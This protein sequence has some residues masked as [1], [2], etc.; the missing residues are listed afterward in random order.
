MNQA[1]SITKEQYDQLINMMQQFHITNANKE[2]EVQMNNAAVN[3]AGIMAFTSFIDFSKPSCGCFKN[4]SDLWIL[5]SEATHHMTFNKN[6]MTNLITLPYP[7]LLRLPNCYRVKVTEI[8]SV[9]ISTQI[10]LYK[11]LFVPSFKY[12]LMS[13]HSL[14]MHLKCIASFSDSSCILQFSDSSCVLLGLSMKS[15]LEIGKVF[16]SL[17]FLFSDCIQRNTPED[18][19]K[20]QVSFPVSSH[21][22]CNSK[23]QC[24][25]HPTLVPSL[26]SHVSRVHYQ[27]H[28]HSY[29]P[30]SF[31]INSIHNN[32]DN[33]VDS[34]SSVSHKF[35]DN[36]LWHNRLGE[37][38]LITTY[39]VNKLPSAPLKS[40]C[41]FEILYSQK[42]FYSHLRS[43]DCLCYPTTPK[44]HRTKFDPRATPH[45][46][47]GYPFGTKGYKVLSLITKKIQ[48]SRDVVFHENIFPFC[49]STPSPSIHAS[50]SPFEH[51]LSSTQSPTHGQSTYEQSPASPD[52]TTPIMSP[53]HSDT[54]PH[55]PIQ[56]PI[57]PPNSVTR[58][59]NSS[60]LND[61]LLAPTLNHS[62]SYSTN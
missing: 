61:T 17:Y 3:F 22:C 62:F 38:I 39:I 56:P 20:T 16:D 18:H 42:P 35:D 36:L 23:L 54:Q 7:L 37:C 57:S 6:Q 58:T 33:A 51:D 48:I 47:V 29:Q 31:V 32:K 19:N 46:F 14:V 41:P 26:S 4:R 5:D 25:S 24:Q 10:T 34:F 53:I 11:V 28:S 40:K 15:P 60:Y 52:P 9:K 2:G 59:P 8:G 1:P 44:P 55:S 13:I 49:L 45:V 30:Q 43:F 21:L 27:S 12:N 50:P